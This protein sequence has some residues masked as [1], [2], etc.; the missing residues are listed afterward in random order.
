[1]TRR[2]TPRA[3]SC[4]WPAPLRIYPCTGP[5]SRSLRPPPEI[6]RRAPAERPPPASRSQ[7]AEAR[8]STAPRTLPSHHH[9]IP[10]PRHRSYAYRYC[11]PE[12]DRGPCCCIPGQLPAS[13]GTEILAGRPVPA[14]AAPSFH[15]IQHHPMQRLCELRRPSRPLALTVVD[16][17]RLFEISPTSHLRPLAHLVLRP[18]ARCTACPPASAM[19]GNAM[20][21]RVCS[22]YFCFELPTTPLC[23]FFPDGSMASFEQSHS[24]IPTTL[25]RPHSAG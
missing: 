12:H 4:P 2:S 5:P 3:R 9:A 23:S 1:M 21:T 15:D 10:Q 18:R 22:R 16:G 20:Q 17:I 6:P 24:S 8:R 7:R 11:S 14:V 25:P 19:D 13:A